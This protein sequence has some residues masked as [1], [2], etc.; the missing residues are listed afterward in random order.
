MRRPVAA[1]RVIGPPF[2]A[3]NFVFRA[4][5]ALPNS[6]GIPR[7]FLSLIRFPGHELG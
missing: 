7:R 4:I 1:F 2:T 5:R 3:A 6:S